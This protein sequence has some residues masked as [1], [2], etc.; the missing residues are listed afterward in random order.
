MRGIN[1]W[2]GGWKFQIS[3]GYLLSW[4]KIYSKEKKTILA[5]HLAHL[6]QS[7][8]S[9]LYSSVEEG[10][11][12]IDGGC[13]KEICEEPFLEWLLFLSD[14][15]WKRKLFNG[16]QQIEVAVSEPG[17]LNLVHIVLCLKLLISQLLFLVWGY[18]FL[19]GPV[20]GDSYVGDPPLAFGE[21]RGWR[22]S[23]RCGEGR[24]IWLHF[25]LSNYINNE[26]SW[27]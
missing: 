17:R 16:E 10:S 12:Q 27:Y 13:G 8:L 25:E 11:P 6:A 4:H 7:G 23:G 21:G 2:D 9:W 15:A 5:D 24:S 3:M 19:N 1:L 18:N 14:T 22:L 20:V 26:Y